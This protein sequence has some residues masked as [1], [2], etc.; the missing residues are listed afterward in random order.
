MKITT[1]FL[2]INP[3]QS[4]RINLIIVIFSFL[5]IGCNKE[6]N[7]SLLNDTGLCLVE[8]DGNFEILDLDEA[9]EYLDGGKEGLNSAFLGTISYPAL[10]RENGIQGSCI[11]NYEITVDGTVENIVAT[12]DPGGGI[13]ASAVD[14]FE[15]ITEGTSFSPGILNENP[16][17]VKKEM[18]I[19]YKL[20]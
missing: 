13:G 16:V 12:Q 8:V 4:N 20:E 18:E 9:P 6:N 7:E 19:R 11:I 17:R 2:G 10:A 3:L 5:I 14:S 15:S 1:N